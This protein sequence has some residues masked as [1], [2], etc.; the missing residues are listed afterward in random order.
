V[1]TKIQGDLQA[2][3]A[4]AAMREKLLGIGFLSSWVEGTETLKAT[5]AQS[6]TTAEL[7]RALGLKP[8]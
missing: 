8:Q 5:Q 3:L 7:V 1:L 6:T 4:S 2:V